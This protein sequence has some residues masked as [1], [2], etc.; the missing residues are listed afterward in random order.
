M[1][2]LD[3]V[4]GAAWR[5]PPAP[6]SACGLGSHRLILHTRQ[7]IRHGDLDEAV[8]DPQWKCFQW[9]ILCTDT[10][11]RGQVEARA[12]QW[13]G[14]CISSNATV[15][16]GRCRVSTTINQGVNT[17]FGPADQDRPTVDDLGTRPAAQR[18]ISFVANRMIGFGHCSMS[19]VRSGLIRYSRNQNQA[20]AEAATASIAAVLVHRL[21]CT[22]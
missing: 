15:Y 20:V 16:Q 21:P 1:S 22:P 19:C 7:V 11:P 4:P 3:S 6:R 5:T 13:T 9:T 8:Y 10:L 12:V 14:D 17:L 18:E 2:E